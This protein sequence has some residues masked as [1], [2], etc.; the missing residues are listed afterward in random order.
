[1]SP[2]G[3]GFAFLKSYSDRRN[4]LIV[5][6]V[7][8]PVNHNEVSGCKT[9]A[10]D[11][12]V[13]LKGKKAV[14]AEIMWAIFRPSEC[15][16]WML[17]PSNFCTT[18]GCFSFEHSKMMNVQE[19]TTTEICRKNKNCNCEGQSCLFNRKYLIYFLKFIFL[20]KIIFSFARK[21]QSCVDGQLWETDAGRFG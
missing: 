8:F 18:K 3:L 21:I 6:F 9:R 12:R 11:G 5:E 4:D 19:M 17:K 15:K 7:K 16:N 20:I 2:D 1:M 10:V 14:V 13:N